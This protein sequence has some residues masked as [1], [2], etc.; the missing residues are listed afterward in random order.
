MII[1]HFQ[2]ARIKKIGLFKDK[3]GGKIMKKFC[4]FRAKAYAY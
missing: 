4:A 1:D 2:Q 3:I